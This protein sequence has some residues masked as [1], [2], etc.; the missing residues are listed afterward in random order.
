MSDQQDALSR[1]VLSV[2]LINDRFSDHRRRSQALPRRFAEMGSGLGRSN[3]RVEPGFKD[4]PCLGQ[5]S[6]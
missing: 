3:P 6:G 5:F 2:K 4:H 1:L